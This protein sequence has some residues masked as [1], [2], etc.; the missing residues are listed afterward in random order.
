MEDALRIRTISAIVLGLAFI[1]AQ[2]Y[3][4]P[5]P[6]VWIASWGAS[7]QIPEPQNAKAMGD[8]RDAT[9]RQIFRLSRWGAT[10]RV[11]ASPSLNRFI[12][13]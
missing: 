11:H 9:M 10:L 12:M 2:A 13:R 1:G 4:R 7:Q 3:A 8:L 6:P 5:K